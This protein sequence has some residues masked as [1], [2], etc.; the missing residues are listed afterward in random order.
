MPFSQC[1]CGVFFKDIRSV[2]V[3]F[4]LELL[5]KLMSFLEEQINLSNLNPVSS[6]HV[7]MA[8]NIHWHDQKWELVGDVLRCLAT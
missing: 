3:Y 2:S 6:C 1:S 4:G 5:V 7:K 8:D